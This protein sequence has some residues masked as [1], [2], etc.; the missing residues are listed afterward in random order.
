[1]VLL[2]GVKAHRAGG[3]LQI[4][5]VNRRTVELGVSFI[6]ALHSC[7]NGNPA[8]VLRAVVGLLLPFPG[9]FSTVISDLGACTSTGGEVDRALDWDLG[10]LNSDPILPQVAG[11]IQLSHLFSLFLA[12]L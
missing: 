8:L 5:G 7:L 9:M 6:S 11:A 2:C 3:R 10:D 4:G 12:F 1:M